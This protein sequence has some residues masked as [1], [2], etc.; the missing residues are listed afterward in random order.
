MICDHNTIKKTSTEDQFT[1]VYCDTK[2][3][4]AKYTSAST[5]SLHTTETFETIQELIDRGLDLGLTCSIEY[6][7]KA[8]EHGATLPDDVLAGLL[9]VV[10]DSGKTNTDKMEALGY[11][12]VSEDPMNYLIS[13]L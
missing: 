2:V 12:K 1:L 4:F 3:L 13:G 11:K 10:W 8:L 6:L 5:E 7:I 9:D